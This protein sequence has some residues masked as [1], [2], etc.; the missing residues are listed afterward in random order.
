MVKT[1]RLLFV[2]TE[3]WFFCSHF[4]DRA[5]FARDNGYKVAVAARE[6]NHREIIQKEGLEFINIPLTRKSINLITELLLLLYIFRVYRNFLPDIVH[7][8]GAKPILYGTVAAYFAGV[9]AIVNAP[10]GMGFIFSSETLLARLLRPFIKLSYK[11]SINPRCSKVIFE[12]H[13]DCDLFIEWGAVRHSDAVIIPGAG[14]DLKI[15]HPSVSNNEKLTVVL[16]ARM[17]IDKGINEF[18]AAARLLRS[19][20]VRARFVLAGSPDPG[21]PTSISIESL[22]RWHLEGCIEYCGWQENVAEFLMTA[23]VVCLP[24][25]REGLPKSLIEACA[26]GLPIVTTDA[27]GCR[28][29]V[30]DGENGF[31][32]PIKSVEPLAD[33]LKKL[34][35]DPSLRRRMGAL[36]RARAEKLYDTQKISSLT[37]E[38]YS[39][40]IVSRVIGKGTSDDQY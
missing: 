36:G 23:D 27:V 31:L 24:S 8:I 39:E 5:R 33:A 32:V 22:D 6:G 16:M 1:P 15:F 20:G 10:I 26:C 17:L 29:V 38:L 14:V 21:N 40:L 19:K 13:E 25:Y 11:F 30:S 9:R 37:L 35:M 2:L 34:I 12:N 7:Q 28:E 3:D 4:I 18:V